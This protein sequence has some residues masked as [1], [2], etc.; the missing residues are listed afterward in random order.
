[1]Y[2]IWHHLDGMQQKAVLGS[3]LVEDAPQAIDD[4]RL[5]H[6]PSLLGTPHDVVFQVE[7]GASVLCISISRRAQH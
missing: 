5:E 7:D 1:M 2:V 3:H 4:R 6:R